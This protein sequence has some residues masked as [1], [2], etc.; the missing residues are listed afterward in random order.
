MFIVWAML[1][2]IFAIVCLFTIR[3]LYLNH[4]ALNQMD[5]TEIDYKNKNTYNKIENF[6]SNHAGGKG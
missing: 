5:D 4:I 2:C 3:T 1:L 6:L